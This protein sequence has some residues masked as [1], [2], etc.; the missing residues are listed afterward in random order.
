MASEDLPVGFS[1]IRDLVTLRIAEAVLARLS[2]DPLQL[3][4]AGS[5]YWCKLR[6]LLTFIVLPGVIC[7][8]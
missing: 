1:K 8:N 7:P 5:P 3:V 2:V 4:R 6:D